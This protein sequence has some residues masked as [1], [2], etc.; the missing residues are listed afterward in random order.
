MS[1]G[2]YQTHREKKEANNFRHQH[3]DL[4]M[5]SCYDDM[6]M[7]NVNAGVPRYRSYLKEKEIAAQRELTEEEKYVKE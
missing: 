6:F 4:N 5:N 3:V 2:L 1:L 7:A